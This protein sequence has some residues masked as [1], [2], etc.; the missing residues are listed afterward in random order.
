[1]QYAEAMLEIIKVQLTEADARIYQTVNYARATRLSSDGP[2]PCCG[3]MAIRF[4][5]EKQVGGLL[6]LR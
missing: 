3:R 5:S 6:A 2:L 1:M 4:I